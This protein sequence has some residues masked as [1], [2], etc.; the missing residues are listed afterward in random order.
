MR[1]RAFVLR[2]RSASDLQ[3]ASDAV[4]L[5]VASTAD[6][7]AVAKANAI[8]PDVCDDPRDNVVAGFCRSV[9]RLEITL[10]N[11]SALRRRL[12]TGELVLFVEVPSR[13]TH[14]IRDSALA[15]IS[16]I[17]SIADAIDLRGALLAGGIVPLPSV[18]IEGS[19]EDVLRRSLARWLGPGLHPARHGADLF[20]PGNDARLVAYGRKLAAELFMDRTLSDA[21]ALALA[22][23]ALAVLLPQETATGVAEGHRRW[24]ETLELLG[25]ALDAA[26]LDEAWE[27]VNDLT[28]EMARMRIRRDVSP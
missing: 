15:Q 26:R 10:Q 16:A 25:D 13:I 28:A 4:R 17:E 2:A 27:L 3:F 20:G 23:D 21:D 19:D 6:D 8:L 1:A 22:R 12:G 24:E 7:A 5:I 18:D 11:A 14:R 9:E